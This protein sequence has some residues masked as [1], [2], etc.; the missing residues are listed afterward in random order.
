MFPPH[1]SACG[2]AGAERPALRAALD[3][4]ALEV[5]ME[6]GEGPGRFRLRL[7]PP[8]PVV[9]GTLQLESLHSASPAQ[10]GVSADTRVLSI[11]IRRVVFEYSA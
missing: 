11:A 8:R 5:A 1:F 2:Q 9:A 7:T 3:G 10:D 6:A 4:A